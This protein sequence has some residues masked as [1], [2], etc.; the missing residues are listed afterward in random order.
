MNI[1]I[2]SLEKN[3]KGWNIFLRVELEDTELSK[4][5]LD[6]LEEVEDYKVYL[7]GDELFFQGYL[8]ILEPW[9]D[10]PLE[11]LL[12]AIKLEVEYKVNQLLGQ[13]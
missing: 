13:D 10:E 7:M 6:A 3:G 4:L 1:E 5:D 9:E 12:K 2:E 11:E 8:E